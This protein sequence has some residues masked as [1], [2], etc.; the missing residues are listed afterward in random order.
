MNIQE[1]ISE[2]FAQKKDF[3]NQPWFH[4][5]VEEFTDLAVQAAIN[6][7][8]FVSIDRH[9]A[10]LTQNQQTLF[11]DYLKEQGYSCEHV[12]DMRDPFYK[13]TPPNG[14][15][16]RSEQTYKVLHTEHARCPDCWVVTI[17]VNGRNHTRDIVGKVIS[18]DVIRKAFHDVLSGGVDD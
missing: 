10:R 6:N 1:M 7:K 17:E 9:T 16:V 11:I 4:G 5:A 18:D 13:I 12:Y 2:K 14:Q 3:L 8:G 15:W